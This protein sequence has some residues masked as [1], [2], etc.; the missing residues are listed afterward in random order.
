MRSG[1]FSQPQMPAGHTALFPPT[2]TPGTRKFRVRCP[3]ASAVLCLQWPSLASALVACDSCGGGGGGGPKKS[4]GADSLDGQLNLFPG[5]DSSWWPSNMG[6]SGFWTDFKMPRKNSWS[7]HR[8][9]ALAEGTGLGA[10]ALL[11]STFPRLVACSG[12]RE[13]VCLYM[14]AFFFKLNIKFREV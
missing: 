4:P 11:H 8:D 9:R 7:G 6:L 13:Y 1:E 3:L 5:L 14:R 10:W 12:T 2:S